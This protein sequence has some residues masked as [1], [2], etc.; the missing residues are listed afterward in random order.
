MTRAKKILKAS[1]ITLLILIGLGLALVGP[2]DRTPL[3][4]QP[5]YQ[6]AIHALDTLKL[7]ANSPMPLQAGW[8]KVNITPG[9]NMPM[10]G[11]MPRKHFDSVHDSLFVRILL[12]QSGNQKIALI[13]ADLLLFPPILKERLQL[14]L[15]S[16]MPGV[17]LY[18]SATHT[19][20]GIG[21]WDDSLVGQFSFGEFDY[22][23]MNT[24]AASLAKAIAKIQPIATYIQYWES[25]ANELI[26]NRIAHKK[27]KK[28]GWLRGIT[29]IREDSSKACLFTFSAHA[30][31]LTKE[32]LTLSA[33]YAAEVINRLEETI[34]FGM[35]MAGMV[36]SHSFAP[37]P[38]E[39]EYDLVK[40]EGELVVEMMA[41]MKAD[42]AQQNI[43]V[44][45]KHFPIPFGPAQLRIGANWKAR[46]WVF[47]LFLDELRGELTYL[48]LGN[49][50]MI[51]TPCDFS[52]EIA[53]NHQLHA[54][55]ASRGLHLIITSF[56]GNY[57]GYITH[58]GHYDSINRT[59]VREM[60]WVGPYHGQYFAEL[61][62][63]L[64]DKIQY[65]QN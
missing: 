24:T 8:D 53:M 7:E 13:N 55:A 43:R 3:D 63:R 2:I 51:G 57:V 11:Y 40:K 18:V 5:F 47:E 25:D 17:F 50:L 64:V 33:D 36:G 20:N 62:K 4:Q 6:Q 1:S 28:D 10:A 46:N 29:L 30:T 21:A 58:D 42:T 39:R 35:F 49:I 26:V 22:E 23:W 16:I 65:S 54:Y 27:G 52:G 9:K 45:S 12:L 59:E 37:M 38:P 31:T 19:H 34:D 41:H 15:E 60:N 48:R 32:N 56:N 61:I 14:E 44:T